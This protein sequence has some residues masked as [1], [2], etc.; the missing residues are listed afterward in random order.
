MHRLFISLNF[1]IEIKKIITDTR[2]KVDVEHSFYRW[3]KEENYHITL[4]FIGN[5]PELK[6]NSILEKISLIEN[7]PVFECSLNRFGF[8]Y[9][10]RKPKILWMG[11]EVLPELDPFVKI[12]NGN[13]VEIGIP[14][15]EKYFKPHL[16]ILRLKG[17]E[18]ELFIEKFKDFHFEP[19]NFTANEISLMESKL[20]PSG[21]IYREIKKYKLK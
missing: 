19:I 15:E 4:K 7:L 18:N 16:T 21:A 10:N 11:M 14:E 3:E 8:F 1:P 20:L 12:L 9:S 5:V 6:L 2:K 13:L 17:F